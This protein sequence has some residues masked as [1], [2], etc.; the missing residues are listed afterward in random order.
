MATQSDF[1]KF[2]HNINPSQTTTEYVSS[3]QNNLRVY[4]KN[5]D[6]YKDIYLETFLSGS[7][8]KKPQ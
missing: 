8:A 4:L 2:L 3:I 7:Y 5:H 6:K 1:D